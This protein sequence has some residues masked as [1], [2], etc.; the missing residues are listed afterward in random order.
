AASAGGLAA[1]LLEQDRCSWFGSGNCQEM[2]VVAFGRALSEL[3]ERLGADMSLWQW[4]RL[5]TLVQKHFLSGRGELGRLLDRSGVPV[6]GDVTCVAS[7]TPDA[8]YA[9]WLGAS[10]RMVADLADARRG[11]WAVDVAGVSGHAGSP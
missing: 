5:H 6:R 1:D 10:Y 9:A 8:N 7:S 2:I 4:G 3:T 11:L